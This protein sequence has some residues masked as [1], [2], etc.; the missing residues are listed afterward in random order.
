LAKYYDALSQQRA[1]HLS[2]TIFELQRTG[3]PLQEDLKQAYKE[4]QE[5]LAARAQM[6]RKLKNIYDSLGKLID[7]D[8]PGEVSGAVNDL[9]DAIEKASNKKLSI[10]GLA[11]VDPKPILDKAV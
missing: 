1:D 10:P 5:A 11:G 4:Q 9:K 2:L 6:A 7:Y 3:S 8:A